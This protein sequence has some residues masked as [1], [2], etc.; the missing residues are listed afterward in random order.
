MSAADVHHL[1]QSIGDGMVGDAHGRMDA[2]D[3]EQSQ[4][5]CI[6]DFVCD[7]GVF[8]VVGFT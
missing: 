6:V 2:E 1:F 4:A 8:A 5:E 7:D 3:A